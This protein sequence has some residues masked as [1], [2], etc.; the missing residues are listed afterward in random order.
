MPRFQQPNQQTKPALGLGWA[1]RV[2]WRELCSVIKPALSNIHTVTACTWLQ[3]HHFCTCLIR[4]NELVKLE[5]K[6]NGEPAEPLSCVVH[7]DAAYRTGKALVSK[8]KE[9]IPRQM[10]RCAVCAL[11][12]RMTTA[13]V[14]CHH[15]AA[16]KP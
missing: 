7:R 8:L 9:L 16:L 4:K 15:T 2:C 3:P 10:F 13:S 14:L 5:I 11:L 6:I 12:P 1:E